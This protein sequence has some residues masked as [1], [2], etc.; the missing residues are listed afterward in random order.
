MRH[1]ETLR[2]IVASIEELRLDIEKEKLMSGETLENVEQWG[3]EV[4]QRIK[5]ADMEILSLTCH[6]EESAMEKEKQ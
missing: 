3:G 2:K 5:Q 1:R 6:L 4:E